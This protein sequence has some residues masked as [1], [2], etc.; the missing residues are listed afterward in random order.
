MTISRQRKYQ[1]KH[2]ALGLCTLCSNIIFKSS[3]CFKHYQSHLKYVKIYGTKKRLE[4]GQVPDK[5]HH[6][7]WCKQVGHNKVSCLSFDMFLKGR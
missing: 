6:C 5:P 4:A 3:F 7:S 2:K 1:L